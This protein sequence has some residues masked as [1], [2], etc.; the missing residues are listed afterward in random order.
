MQLAA[1]PPNETERLADLHSYALLDTLDERG[2]DDITFLASYICETPVSLVTLVDRD[3]QW[4]KSAVGADIRETTRAD[5]FC[6]HLVAEPAVL[7]VQDTLLDDRFHDNPLV[8]GEFGIRFYAG[9]P[10]VTPDGHVIGS[11][12]VIDQKPRLLR[13]EQVE[14]LE[15]LARSVMARME[16]R[17]QMR[18]REIAANAMRTAEKLAAVGR[19][20]SSI[21]HEINNPLQ[22]VTNLLFMIAKRTRAARA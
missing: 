6:S 7:I 11:V 12:C 3:R 20:A 1:I 5:S 21:A 16:L 22:S 19:M 15:A 4:F 9:A 8:T 2:Y 17:R 18:E 14:A 13:S 10:L